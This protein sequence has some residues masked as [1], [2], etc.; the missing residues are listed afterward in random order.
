MHKILQSYLRRLTNI[1][2]NNRSL[3]LPRLV[4]KQ[5]VDVHKFDFLNNFSSYKIIEWLIAG[6]AHDLEGVSGKKLPLCAVLDSRDEQNNKMS[7][8]LKK[9]SR[10]EKFIFEEQGSKDLFIGWPFVKG[11]FSD[12][13]IVRCPLMFFPVNLEQHQTNEYGLQWVLSIRDEVNVSLN[14][15]FLLAYAY[16]NQLP[17]DESL[18]EK[19][20]DDF[21]TD[22]RI[23]RTSLY[24]LFKESKFILNFNQEIFVDKLHPFQDVSKDELNQSE[25][26]GE[27]K[28]YPEAVLGIFPQAGSYLV[29]DYLKLIENQFL[30]DIED[31]FAKRASTEKI[32]YSSLEGLSVELKEKLSKDYIDYASRIKEEQI[33]CPFPMDA[34]QEK[35]IRTVKRGSSLVV[36]G[37]PGTGKSQMITNLIGDYIA[38]GKRVLVVCQKKAALDVVYRRLKEKDVHPFI[39]LV[40]DFKNDRK[41]IYAQLSKQIESLY[42]YQHKNNSLDTIYLERNFL[43]YSRRIEQICDEL[44][45]FKKALFDESEAGIS[46]KELYLTSDI[47]KPSVNMRQEYRNFFI[48]E[49]HAFLKKLRTYIAYS[50]QFEKENYLLYDRKPFIEYTV[51]DLKKIREIVHDIPVFKQRIEKDTLNILKTEVDFVSC[52][53]LQQH[54]ENISSFTQLLQ[55]EKSYTYF[56]HM[57]P[58]ID[59][60]ADPLWLS[61]IERIVMECYQGHG[62]EVNLSSDELGKCQRIIAQAEEARNGV[63]SWVWWKYFSKDKAYVE[64]ILKQNELTT[65]KEGFRTIAE[66][67]DARLNLEHNLTK[68]REKK[69][70]MDIPEKESSDQYNKSVVE[71]WF[72]HQENALHATLIFRSLRNF[73]EY[74]NIKNISYQDLILRTEALVQV[75]NK[76]APQIK[77]WESYLSPGQV[78]KLITQEHSEAFLRVLDRDFDALCDF[79]TLNHRLEPYEKAVI[80][81]LL[82]EAEDRSEEGIIAFFQNS[83][84]L[85]WIDHLEMKFPQLRIVSS[86]QMADLEEEL[87]QC[88]EEKLKVSQEI[89]HMKLREKT[90][91][92]VEYN[93]LNNLVTYRDLSHQIN[94]KRKV[95]PLRKVMGTFEDEVFN[96]I[97]CWLASPE[98]V[99]AIFPMGDKPIFD[100]VIFDEASQCFAEKG[101]P[102]MYRGQQV[103]ITGD[104]Q[105][106]SPNDLYQARWEEDETEHTEDALALEATSLLELAQGYLQSL[107]LRAHYRSKTLDLIDFSNHSFYDDKLRLLPD[108]Y[109]ANSNQPAIQ[110]IKVE[111]TWQKQVNRIESQEVVKQVR[112][113]LAEHPEKS[114]GVICFN[115]KQQELIQD[116]LEAAAL[117]HNFLIPENLF[118][119]NIENVQGDERDIIIFSTAYAPNEQGKLILQFG[120]LNQAKGENRLNVAVTR[121]REKIFL[122]TSLMPQQLDVSQTK[123]EGPKLLKKY[124]EYAWDVSHKKYI[125]VLPK[126]GDHHT[127][128]FLASKLKQ[129]TDQ[130]VDGYVAEREL[131]FAD[132]SIKNMEDQYIGL[133]NTD[134]DIYYQSESAKEIHAYRPFLLSEKNWK[135]KNIY[136][137]QYWQQNEQAKEDVNRFIMTD[138]QRA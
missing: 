37:P 106:L 56:T 102:A 97:P 64:D 110:Y 50:N 4:A 14:K 86:R 119:K 89:L 12:G 78:S 60:D 53:N 27:L 25:K 130:E 98:T 54:S 20:F 81:H 58:N 133:I 2:S 129:W 74:F 100:L 103:V 136:S 101:I 28:L 93:R 46:I 75:L 132:L 39:A 57:V 15:T 122:I 51:E 62:P 69:W 90:Y 41:D 105:Q 124:L 80:N 121:S 13:T 88:I 126:L 36:Q 61:N 55:E 31:F 91:Y 9:L 66:K 85:A 71:A 92:D 79:D 42:D 138:G 99:S 59:K 52:E 63:F 127:D 45:E 44:D 131:P 67:I 11:K 32:V 40:H 3:Y 23:F 117:E 83:I 108:F 111:G 68:L 5:F 10:T 82:E 24:Q 26:E 35:A 114:M 47:N 134:D 113:L 38:Q 112:K 120:S 49:M 34:F 104:S 43:Q 77:Y 65:D 95:W 48:P 76:I 137:R 87:Q 123:N 21:D 94:K 19:G 7:Q 29:P 18:S 72:N 128:W 116:D 30:P 73:N 22:S 109:D 17:F 33:F 6:G 115:I 135:F 107:Q 1:T 70:I 96:L 125:P 84:R 8:Q 118:V 16:Y